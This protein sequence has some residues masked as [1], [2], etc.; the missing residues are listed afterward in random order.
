MNKAYTTQQLQQQGVQFQGSGGC[1]EGNRDYGF[2][3]AFLDSD[4]GIIYPSRLAN[5]LPSPVHSLNGLP[6]NLVL[7]RDIHGNVTA[8]KGSVISGFSR[9][10]L[11][12]SREECA[13]LLKVI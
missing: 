13:E 5:G 4:S 6:D 10:G 8:V 12:Y 3:P 11:F 1:S 2:E 9:E 7:A